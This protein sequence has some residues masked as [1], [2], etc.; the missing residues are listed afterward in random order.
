MCDSPFVS[1]HFPPLNFNQA[2]MKAIF[3]GVSVRRIEGLDR[4]ITADLSRM[5]RDYA[6]ERTAAGRPVPE[7]ATYLISHG[8]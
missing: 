3:M 4:R 1:E 7:D 8:D 5:A 6:S 2:V